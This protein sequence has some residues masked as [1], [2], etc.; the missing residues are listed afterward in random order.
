VLAREAAFV[1]DVAPRWADRSR[2]CPC[3]AACSV[4]R[5][6]V[7]WPTEAAG[8]AQPWLLDLW[9]NAE[10][11]RVAEVVALCC[12]RHVRIPSEVELREMGIDETRL[13][14]LLDMTG[15]F[16]TPPVHAWVWDGSEAERVVLVR[17]PM[18][19]GVVLYDQRLRALHDALGAPLGE[20]REHGVGWA[21]GGNA[22][23]LGAA[24]TADPTVERA[25][26]ECG[27]SI[28][29][30]FWIRREVDLS[31]SPAG[32]FDVVFRRNGRT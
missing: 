14:V 16:S 5:R 29:D 28:E 12:D 1:F 32:A 24:G 18:I 25:I 22:L 11:Q 9:G 19:S 6:L 17:G 21:L 3:G 8:H 13:A 27:I 4:E 23:A 15:T 31:S 10:S 7:A 26:A 30:P 20:D 2:V